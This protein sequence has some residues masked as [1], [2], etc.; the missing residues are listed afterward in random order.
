MAR[1][2]TNKLLEMAEENGPTSFQ[3]QMIRDLLNFLSED[4]AKQ[5]AEQYG[6]I[7][8]EDEEE[9]DEPLM[10]TWHDIAKD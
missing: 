4:E 5:F 2:Y 8:E 9:D 7:E 3:Y 10:T 6:Y 1:E